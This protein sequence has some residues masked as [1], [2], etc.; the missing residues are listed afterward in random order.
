MSL[1]LL[2]IALSLLECLLS[3]KSASAGTALAFASLT[4]TRIQPAFFL[5][6]PLL[7]SLQYLY[8]KF[9]E[10]KALRYTAEVWRRQGFL[11]AEAL[12]SYIHTQQQLRA[13]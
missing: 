13:D 9:R 1:G 6:C 5:L 10:L 12:L 8:L 7:L 11:E 3:Q 2:I 4:L